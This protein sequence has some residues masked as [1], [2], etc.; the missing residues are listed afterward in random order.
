MITTNRGESLITVLIAVGIS[1]ILAMVMA[2]LFD[3]SQ[4]QQKGVEI[5]YET[6]NIA[7][8]IRSILSNS[9]NCVRTFVLDATGTQR[10]LI[11]DPQ[12]ASTT[13]RVD[14]PT[15]FKINYWGQD[16]SH[17]Y[18]LTPSDYGVGPVIN[19]QVQLNLYVKNYRSVT[20]SMVLVARFSKLLGNYMGADRIIE[21]PLYV[22]LTTTGTPKLEWCV[23][24]ESA[25]KQVS[26]LRIK[27]GN[28]DNFTLPDNPR[29]GDVVMVNRADGSALW[30]S[31]TTKLP[32]GVS[33]GG[34]PTKINGDL[35][36]LTLDQDIGFTLMYV[37]ETLGWV[38]Q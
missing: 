15:G 7:E 22:R 6:T 8:Q 3:N 27:A 13:W 12:D 36:P 5:K 10:D 2:S 37:G 38:I 26:T 16:D 24:Q 4:K 21:I 23:A 20:H 35:G 30:T 11:V 25:D 19:N 32:S 14:F 17:T 9:D 29:E 18:I 28:V 31:T 34:V 1:G 33:G